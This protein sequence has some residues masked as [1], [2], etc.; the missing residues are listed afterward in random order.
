MSKLKLTVKSVLQNKGCQVIA[1]TEFNAFILE[2]PIMFSHVP[3]DREKVCSNTMRWSTLISVQLKESRR[4]VHHLLFVTHTVLKGKC[5]QTSPV[6][7][8]ASAFTSQ[9]GN[10]WVKSW[11]TLPLP[12]PT[13]LWEHWTRIPKQLRLRFSWEL[14]ERDSGGDWQWLK[15]EPNMSHPKWRAQM[16]GSHFLKHTLCQRL[17]FW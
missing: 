14:G 3:T 2:N 4:R 11:I 7:P 10:L 16:L 17:A 12:S 13:L 1:T 6:L 5:T 15:Q 9:T 8:R